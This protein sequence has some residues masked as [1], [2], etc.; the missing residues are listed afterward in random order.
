[1]SHAE[2]TAKRGASAPPALEDV[3]ELA[4]GRIGVDIELK[5]PGYV[6]EVIG[7]LTSFGLDR[8]LLTS[9]IDAALLEAKALAPD[10]RT[11]LLVGI[12]SRRLPLRMGLSVLYPL[13]R[14]A[15]CR[16]DYLGVDLRLAEAGVLGRAASA[17]TPCL[18]WTVNEPNA[19]DRYLADPGIA[20]LITDVP[21][22]VLERRD[23]RQ[24]PNPREE[25]QP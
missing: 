4:R 9:F 8:C 3:L 19:I 2:L 1:L 12:R 17:G 23:R 22:L 11:G 24:R 6:D 14:L 7:R 5:E 21:Q 16:A 15:R 18:V 25:E 20:G 13:R 10:L